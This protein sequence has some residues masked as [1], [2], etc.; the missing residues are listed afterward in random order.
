[1]FGDTPGAAT[2]LKAAQARLTELRAALEAHADDVH[3]IDGGRMALAGIDEQLRSGEPQR[4]YLELA[5]GSLMMA[6]GSVA[7][8]V[9]VAEALK[10]AVDALFA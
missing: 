1:M 9:A 5:L 10:G 4:P 6:I 2:K 8:V 3:S 7:D